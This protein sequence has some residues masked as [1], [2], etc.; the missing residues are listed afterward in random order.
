MKKVLAISSVLLG[1]V[2]L[3]GCGQQPVSQTQPTT[4]VPVAQTPAQPAD[5]TASWQTYTNTKYGFEI[6]YPKDWQLALN[7]NA[8]DQ[9]PGFIHGSGISSDGTRA[10]DVDAIFLN[11]VFDAEGAPLSSKG[12]ID[13]NAQQL[14][15]GKGTEA[16]AP[17]KNGEIFWYF[18]QEPDPSGHIEKYP[19]ATIVGNLSGF[20]AE[21][22]MTEKATTFNQ[23]EETFK[24][25][26]STFKFTK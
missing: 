6:K 12:S 1:V 10:I 7:V 13:A 20:Y 17:I 16:M 2:F 9:L 25:V 4:T 18:N 11:S 26:L 15:K 21:Y 8:T 14:F 19:M 3:A 22:R 5:E 23:A 24:K